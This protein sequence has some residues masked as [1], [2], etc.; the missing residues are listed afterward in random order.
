LLTFAIVGTYAVARVLLTPETFGE[1]GHYR[2]VALKELA[3][4]QP[5]YAGAKACAECHDD[6]VTRLAKGDHKTIACETCHG[7]GRK[8]ADDPDEKPPKG[9]NSL[10]LRCHEANPARPA[11]LKQVTTK[12]HFEGRCAECHVAHQP[13]EVP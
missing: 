2:G 12:D 4:R 7:P 11:F 1:F 5:T 13:K 10:C 8:H 9:G 6:Q 3:S